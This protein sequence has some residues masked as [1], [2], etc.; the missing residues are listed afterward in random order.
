MNYKYLTA[1]MVSAFAL[2]SIQAQTFNFDDNS[3]TD[4]TGQVSLIPFN[5][6]GSGQLPPPASGA[7][8]TSEGELKLSATHFG[9][10]TSFDPSILGTILGPTRIGVVNPTPYQDFKVSCLVTNPGDLG[11]T[12][13]NPF[14]YLGARVTDVG[15]GTTKAYA[16]WLGYS[17]DGQLSI[18][19]VKIIN[20]AP[21]YLLKEDGTEYSVKINNSSEQ[22]RYLITFTGIGS[23]LRVEADDLSTEA[24]GLNFSTVDTEFS[25]G[26]TAI[27]L[28]A[29]FEQAEQSITATIDNFTAGPAPILPEG[30]ALTIE[31]SVKL[32]WPVIEGN[33]QLESATELDGFWVEV[34]A[35]VFEV[36]GMLQATVVIDEV[37]RYYRIRPIE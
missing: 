37:N 25:A 24:P 13:L 26:A 7:L 36:D 6:F 27:I 1:L 30:P 29:P 18:G 17:L 8:D 10:G 5:I 19:L 11:D 34:G 22:S 31:Q 12:G 28:A 3:L 4:T 23:V 35:P 9:M 15:P 16:A 32:T 33:F 14:L 20:E 2:H 21:E